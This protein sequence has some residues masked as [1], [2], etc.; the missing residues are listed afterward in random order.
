MLLWRRCLC[1]RRCCCECESA[2]PSPDAWRSSMQRLFVKVER[3]RRL[4]ESSLLDVPCERGPD[5]SFG[6]GL[7]D[8]N[9]RSLQHAL[10]LLN[11]CIAQEL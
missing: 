5:G 8:D 9:V 4:H 7:T 2:L 11:V 10:L 1:W 6:L 3:L